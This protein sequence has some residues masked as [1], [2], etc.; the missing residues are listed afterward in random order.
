MEQF[1]EYWIAPVPTPTATPTPTPSPTPAPS[2]N[3][4]YSI[5]QLELML[6]TGQRNELYELYRAGDI[7]EEQ[8]AYLIDKY[9]YGP[10]GFIGDGS[11]GSSKPSESTYNLEQ[12]VVMMEAGEVEK[13][14][15]LYA[16]GL[17]TQEQYNYLADMYGVREDGT[18]GDGSDSGS[19]T[20]DNGKYTTE[21][22]VEMLAAGETEKLK[23]LYEAGEITDEQAEYLTDI[24]GAE[25]H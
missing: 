14:Q 12:L 22:L 23:V 18:L 8:Y 2:L 20:P 4:K 7:T 19:S 9:G 25:W 1:G 5:E 3:S 11:S 17:I 10:D 21:E 13:V 24:Y 6:A 15:Q 16:A